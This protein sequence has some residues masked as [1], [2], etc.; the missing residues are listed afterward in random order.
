MRDYLHVVLD[1]FYPRTCLHC[2]RNLNNSRELYLC[3][4]CRKQIPYV[5]EFHCVRCG[6]STGHYAI[7]LMKEGCAVCKGRRLSFDAMTAIAHYDGVAKT[8]IHKFKYAR[9]KFLFRIVNDIVLSQKKLRGVVSDVDVVVP[10]PLHW[11]KKMQRGFNQS[12]LLSLGIRRRFSKPVSTNN[13][14][15]IK[16]TESQTHLSRTQRQANIHNAFFVKHPKLFRGKRILLVDDVLTTGVTASECSKK[17]K[18]AGA[19]SV[20]L[21]VLANAE[22][23]N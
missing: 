17:L 22:N 2:N 11:F 7:S 9:Q 10:V 14:C 23:N 18:E 5:D 12:E 21:L 19:G 15:R 3:E 20:H 13:L 16:N 6:A 4:E 1:F 8:L